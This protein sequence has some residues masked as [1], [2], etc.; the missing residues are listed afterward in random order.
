MIPR[1]QK[2]WFIVGLIGIAFLTVIDN[3]GLL[4]S[5]GLW[6]N[7][8]HGPD[9]LIVVI[10]FLSGLTLDTRQIR[11]GITDVSGILLALTLIFI[12]AP[13]I[14]TTYSLLPLP[15]EIVLGLYL[16]AIMPSTLSS[17]VVMTG[18]AGGNI[19]HALLITIIANTLAVITIPPTLTYLLGTSL[20][21]Q[22][23]AIDQTAIMLKIAAL[24]LLPLF[25][26][27]ILGNRLPWLFSS[28][29]SLI[30][31]ANQ[32]AILVIVWMA[33]CSGRPAIVAKGKALLPIVATVASFHLLLVIVA[34]ALTSLCGIKK[35]RRESI[36]FM[37]GQKTL[38]LSIIL[39]VSLFPE[40]G[41]ALVVCVV[42]HIV[43]LIMD[44]F[45]IR[46][47]L[48]SKE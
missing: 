42:H 4:V 39:Q 10:F 35:G 36:V 6:L 7:A 30:K 17:G 23:I 25:M 46:Y 43:H 1:L 14:A 16:V 24:V 27:I 33:M 22:P 2:N 15:P 13:F 5:P 38:P 41:I 37:G 20:E 8:H 19:A 44:A 31:N 12:I 48:E 47:L 9:T 18:S 40:Y 26:G 29:S 21:N 45:L 3:S 28:R 34:F 11:R 32:M